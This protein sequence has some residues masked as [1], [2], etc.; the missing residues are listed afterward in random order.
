MR[1]SMNESAQVVLN[2]SG[3]GSVGIGPL[4]AA[5][6]WYPNMISIR[7]SSNANEPTFNYYWGK[8]AGQANQLGGTFVG[9]N[10]QDSLSG[11]VLH[12]GDSW[13]CVWTGGDA[14]ATASVTLTGEMEV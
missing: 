2:G 10:N 1:I 11:R 13:L 7:V 14:G 3:N 9:S 4:Y 12:P 6:T 5:Q 8:T